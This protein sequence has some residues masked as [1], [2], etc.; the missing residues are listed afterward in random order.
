MAMQND[1]EHDT[2]KFGPPVLEP[3]GCGLD[4]ADPFQIVPSALLSTA[5]QK[6][7]EAHDSDWNGLVS[8]PLEVVHEDP[9]NV[10]ALPE[11]STAAQKLVVGHDTE[12]RLKFASIATGADHAVPL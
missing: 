2:A 3:N 1:A 12:I 9:L 4:H 8:T 10:K 7:G 5:T 11:L 6:E